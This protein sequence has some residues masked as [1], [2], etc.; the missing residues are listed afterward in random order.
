MPTY[1]LELDDRMSRPARSA[2]D[3]VTNLDRTLRSLDAT[4]SRVGRSANGGGRGG[5]SLLLMASSLSTVAS[6]AFGAARSVAGIGLAFGRNVI[7]MA[8]FRE[9]SLAALET[10]MGSSEA[11]GRTFQNAITVANQTPLDTRDVVSSFQRFAVAGFSERELA[12]LA[13]ATADLGAAFGRTASDS[14]SLVVSQMRGAGKMDR[15]DLRQLLN[16]GVNTGAVLDSIA[17]QMNISGVDERARRQSVLSALSHGRVTGDVGIQAALDATRGRLDRGDALGTFARRQSETLTGAL[18]NAANAWDNLLMGFGS[19]RLPGVVAFRDAVLAVT[20]ALDGAQPAGR[21]LR[22]LVSDVVNVVGVELGS[23]FNAG[24]ISTFAD[25]IET[26]R[27]VLV[28]VVRGVIDFGRG[29]EG[30]FA[31]TLGPVIESLRAFDETGAGSGDTMMELGRA[32]GFVAAAFVIGVGVVA[33][34]VSGFVELYDLASELPDSLSFLADEFMRLPTA[35]VDGF[36]SGLDAEWTR[37]NARVEELGLGVADTVRS[38]LGIHSPSRVMMEL[39]GYTM[40]GF[41]LGLA[42]GVGRV[43]RTL[44]G[45]G[46]VGA[47]PSAESF[48]ARSQISITIPVTVQAAPGDDPEDTGRRVGRGIVEELVGVFELLNTGAVPAPE[49]S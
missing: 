20:G 24:S 7:E 48:G 34:A 23:A 47:T 26:V 3:A 15:G 9:S 44:D 13:A 41:E 11:A 30:G 5:D 22:G 19:E 37:V 10:V 42:D 6:T 32:L 49:P 21:A 16:S 35:I 2:R 33:E 43:G 27:P 14:F 46:S 39:G 1:A 31:G 12:P 45:L 25:V 4:L 17:R 28:D 8:S 29:L 38:A 18:S 40:Q 36:I